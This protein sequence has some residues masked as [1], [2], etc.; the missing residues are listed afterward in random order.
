M[1]R[2]LPPR[3]LEKPLQKILIH[4]LASK[5]LAGRSVRGL[6]IDL[7]CLGAGRLKILA[8]SQIHGNE[9]TSTRA[10]LKL[11]NWLVADKNKDLLRQVS[12]Y[13]IPQLNPDGANA[14][15]RHNSSG[16]DLNR[17]A[18]ELLQPESLALSNA[19]EAVKP[20]LCLNLHDQ[21]TVYAAGHGGRP[22]T[23]SFLAP[24]TGEPLT[25]TPAY[26]QAARLIAGLQAYL[27]QKIPRGVSR[28][29]NN[30]NP[31]CFGEYFMSRGIPTILF[32]AGHYPG[33]YQ[34][35]QVKDFFYLA[36]KKT[37]K[38]F[39]NQTYTNHETD[40]YDEIP[41]NQPEFFDLIIKNATLE[42]DGQTT[43]GQ[44][45]AVMFFEKL[46]GDDVRFLPLIVNYGQQSDWQV[47]HPYFN[48]K[49]RIDW[50]AHH[51]ITLNQPVRLP[52]QTCITSH[53]NFIKDN[54][55]LS[56]VNR[57]VPSLAP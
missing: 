4:E 27:D 36:L 20:Q 52:Y 41:V 2:Y 39:V 19:F 25:L 10:L 23:M 11:A 33:D 26:T 53:Y 14:H 28:F 34:R 55:L 38:D 30:Y 35:N 7:Y 5:Q 57:E 21:R 6:D 13:F 8:W 17:D 47:Q 3:K 1:S 51:T 32:E 31:D 12:F 37:L 22:A 45:L 49:K 15:Q 43:P 46:V 50:R 29:D 16:V 56:L 40:Q 9:S 48:F 54:Q 42:I 24:V 44:D 18:L